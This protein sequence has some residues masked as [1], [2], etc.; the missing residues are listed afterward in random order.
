MLALNTNISYF[1]FFEY[2]TSS[3]FTNFLLNKVFITW[4]ENNLDEFIIIL[5]GLK[6]LVKNIDNKERLEKQLIKLLNLFSYAKQ[7]ISKLSSKYVYI[8]NYQN[9]L[10]NAINLINEIIP[11]LENE[12]LKES[13]LIQSNNFFIQHI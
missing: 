9:K 11:V 8:N 7:N 10:D 1:Q 2:K 6:Q 4:S 12:I 13:V 5:T 3:F